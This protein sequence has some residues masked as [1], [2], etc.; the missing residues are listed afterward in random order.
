[1]SSKDQNVLMCTFGKEVHEG[2]TSF[3][4]YLSSKFFYD[5]LGDKLFQ[6]IMDLPEYYLTNAEYD[7][8]QLH[9]TNIL[10]SFDAS[11]KGFDLIELGAGDGKKTKVLLKELLK[12]SYPVT[13][14]PIDISKHAIDGLVDN[15]A[16]ELSELQVQGQIGEYFEVLDRLKHISDRKKVIMVLGSNIGNL[17]HPR[18]IQF[19]K[20][21]NSVMNTDDE[22]FIGFDQK[23]HPQKVLDAYNDK[24][25]VTAAFNKNILTRIN[26]ELGGNFD[27]DAFIH[28]E[29]YDPESGTAKSYLVSTKKQTVDIDC[30][31]LQVQ[32]EAWE[33]IHTEISQKYDDDTVKWLAEESGFVITDAFSDKDKYYKNYVF[34]K[35]E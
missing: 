7:I 2:L 33:S 14:H 15:L 30:L 24:T 10:K 11:K 22:V 16:S 17:L 21:L 1:M 28:W 20:K 9:K 35:S 12:E 18:A 34:K 29:V 31:E 5:E 19:L 27:L 32:F 4:K 3:P 26:R 23:K 6:K 25:G 8:F 13:Y